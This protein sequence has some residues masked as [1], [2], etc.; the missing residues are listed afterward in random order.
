MR[1]EVARWCG[2]VTWGDEAGRE[3]ISSRRI[4][5]ALVRRVGVARRGG[6]PGFPCVV[7]LRDTYYTYIVYR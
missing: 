7:V 6:G 5:E 4:G 2:V 1:G 3:G